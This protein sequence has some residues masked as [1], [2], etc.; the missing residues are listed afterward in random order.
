MDDQA[1][2][3]GLDPAMTEDPQGT[4]NRPV[5]AVVDDDRAVCG[6]LKFALELEG[7]AVRTY[8]SGAELLHAGDLEDCNCFVIDQRMPEMTGMELVE[9]LR[10]R[11]VLTPVILIISHPNAALSARARNA[12]IPI[13]EKPFLGNALVERIREACWA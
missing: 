3:I 11:L 10:E 5:V 13:V 6:S 1:S 4:A 7:F 9:V 2:R 8:H 12:A